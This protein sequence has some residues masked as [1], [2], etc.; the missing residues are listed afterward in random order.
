MARS[1]V[2]D[3]STRLCMYDGSLGLSMQWP[4][5]TERAEH[6]ACDGL[7]TEAFD[8]DAMVS[9]HLRLAA[10]NGEGRADLHFG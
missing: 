10:G 9:D 7:S 3:W 8:S 2:D 6:R 1:P 5:S 4:G